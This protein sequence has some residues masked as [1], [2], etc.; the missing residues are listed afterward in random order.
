MAVLARGDAPR[1]EALAV[2]HAIDVVDDRNLGVAR[3]QEIGVHGM[4][5]AARSTV[6]TAA[7]SACPITWPPNTR[8]QPTCGRAA[9]EQVHVQWFEIENVEQILD[10]GGHDGCGFRWRTA[11]N[12]AAATARSQGALDPASHWLR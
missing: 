5:R 8:C 4:R 11:V 1:G 3:Q 10:G 12:D 6:R 7:T 2:A 9:A